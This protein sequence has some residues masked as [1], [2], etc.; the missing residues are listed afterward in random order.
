[1]DTKSNLV[2]D[3]KKKKLDNFKKLDKMD[4]YCKK[5]HIFFTERD[6]INR[7][8]LNSKGQFKNFKGHLNKAFNHINEIP[9]HQNLE[10]LLTG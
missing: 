5:E 7:L 8:I 3:E 1:M 9:V 10:K 4:D 2:K 6:R